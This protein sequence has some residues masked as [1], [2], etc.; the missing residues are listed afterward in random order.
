MEYIGNLRR[1]YSDCFM[2][3]EPGLYVVGS[4]TPII[5]AGQIVYSETSYKSMQP[6]TSLDEVNEAVVDSEGR[7]IIPAQFMR[8]KKKMLRTEPV[9]PVRAL[10][11]ASIIAE[12]FID[13]SLPYTEPDVSNTRVYEHIK[14]EYHYLID[15]G[16]IEGSLQRLIND[17]SLFVNS[18]L[19][20][21]YFF[22]QH[23]TDLVI[24][25]S[26]DYRVYDWTRKLENEAFDLTQDS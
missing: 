20:N 8:H 19:W 13:S 18:K 24:K 7:V 6:I 23:S 15:E 9:F 14:P 26:V 22:E 1:K 3:P 2:P 5:K 10:N 4:T 21:I 12:D 16:Y 11:V 25:Q 17:T